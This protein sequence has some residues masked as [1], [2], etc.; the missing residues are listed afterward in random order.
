MSRRPVH[1]TYRKGSRVPQFVQRIPVDVRGPLIGHVIVVPLGEGGDAVTCAVKPSTQNIRF[2]L[3]TSDPAE[4]RRRE[5][6]ATLFL[7]RYFEAVRSAQPLEL[8]HRQTIALAG[9]F[10]AMWA[11]EPDS[12]VA[13]AY[14]PNIASL[15]SGPVEDYDREAFRLTALSEDIQRQA[16]EGGETFAMAV[17][18]AVADALLGGHGIPTIVAAAKLRL[19]IALSRCL[20]EA[21]KIRARIAGGDFSPDVNLAK[22]PRWE[23]PEEATKPRVSVSLNALLEGW[24][25]EHSASGG[26]EGTYELY[27]SAFRTFST[28]LKH[29]DASRVTEGDIQR[30]KDHR[31]STPSL[32][33]KR[34]ISARS[35]KHGDLAAL[36]TIFSW[37]VAN[38][39]L[40][41]NPVGD[42]RVKTG[43]QV[44]L[45]E[46]DF[47]DAEAL[48]ILRAALGQRWAKR[49]VPWLCAYTGARVGEIV[50]LRRKDFR[51]VGASWVISISPEA[52]TVKGKELREVPLH[53]HL[54]EMG[55]L[56]FLLGYKEPDDLLFLKIKPKSTLRKTWKTQKDNIRRFVRTIVADPNVAPNHGWRHTFK[57]KGNEAGIEEKVL[58]AI[59]GHAPQS[60]GRKYG[61]VSLKAKEAAVKRFPRWDIRA[62]QE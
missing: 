30:Y 9:E 17:F 3:Q 47:T 50:Q 32:Q 34:P 31:L 38:R 52:G 18:G 59:C 33:T 24:W 21:L 42:L 25:T 37:A 14:T 6:A 28:F 15:T 13:P 55:F 58:D 10:Y 11:A 48:S 29:D 43:K 4:A 5:V 1:L 40:H 7:G 61:T 45:R 19:V 41:V 62:V 46:R 44:K 20:P 56:D 57:T 2:S 39:K 54:I 16:L 12:P 60:E 8:T 51:K 26:A 27:K 23:P 35:F 22:Y 53:A 49:W 36:K